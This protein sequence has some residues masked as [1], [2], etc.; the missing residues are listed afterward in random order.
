MAVGVGMIM[1]LFVLPRMAVHM[2]VAVIVIIDLF[3]SVFVLVLVH[4]LHAFFEF[5]PNYTRNRRIL[6]APR[7]DREV[8]SEK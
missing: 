6:Q 4:M 3:R 2:A 1:V 5:P 7:G 8:K